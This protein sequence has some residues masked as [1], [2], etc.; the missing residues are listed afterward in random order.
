MTASPFTVPSA[1]TGLCVNSENGQVLLNWTVPAL[2]GGRDIDYYVVYQDGHLVPTNLIG[3][4]IMISGLTNGN[5]YSFSVAACNLAGTG[6]LSSVVE[7]TPFTVPDAP[8]GLIAIASISQVTLIWTAPTFDGGRAIDGYH[9]YQSN[10][11]NGPFSLITS[12][13]GLNY[14]DTDLTN[15]LTYW[16]RLYAFNSA[17]EGSYF[18]N[19][20]STP[21]T[22]P[23]AP[24]SLTQTSGNAQVSL[25]WAS[26]SFNGGRDIDYYVVYQDGLPLANHTAELSVNIMELSN[27]QN[28]SFAVAAHNLAGESIQSAGVL[29]MPYKTPGT[30]TG[31]AAIR[32]DNS[33]ALNWTA[34]TNDGGKQIIGYN[35]YRSTTLDGSFTHIASPIGLDYNDAGLVNGQAYWYQV[36]AINT[37]GEGNLSE[38]KGEQAQNN[39]DQAINNVA[40]GFVVQDVTGTVDTDYA[41]MT[42]ITIQMRL[43][44]GS[45]N[46][47]MDL[48]SIQ[49]VSGDDNAMLSFAEGVANASAPDSNLDGLYGADSTTTI[50]AAWADGNHVVQQGDMI[51][52]HLAVGERSVLLGR[53]DHQDR[54]GIRI[55]HPDQ[56][57]DPVLLQH[58]ICQS[59]M[60]KSEPGYKR[61][62]DVKRFS[63]FHCDVL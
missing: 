43:Q 35:L 24:A 4:S 45:P 1:P 63:V 41:L 15:G 9:V 8:K 12:T 14:N 38:P 52:V 21:Y 34:P 57:R 10:S 60:M 22:L 25:Q 42:D 50:D 13:S 36:S 44:A 27:G 53:R 19:I 11:I 39:G 5:N 59:E 20:S 58:G 48:V 54:S 49:F 46:M 16:Y 30:P 23:N 2:N 56:L 29:A 55:G 31:L 40:S 7:G 37:A 33:M 61:F 32:T 62:I 3:T 47:N 28:Y 18:T 51:T 17:G 6:N 26:P